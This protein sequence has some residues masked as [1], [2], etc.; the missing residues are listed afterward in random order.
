[1]RGA[2]ISSVLSATRQDYY[3]DRT[4][5]LDL[6]RLPLSHMG[7]ELWVGGDDDCYD[8]LRV[9]SGKPRW[10]SSSSLPGSSVAL[11]TRD[12]YLYVEEKPLPDSP[13]SASKLFY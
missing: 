12:H 8:R 13:G 5:E 10:R 11:L 3:V 7:E 9:A 1:M 2:K 6:Q 4:A